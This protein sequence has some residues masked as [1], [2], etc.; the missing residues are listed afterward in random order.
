MWR[1]IAFP[2]KPISFYSTFHHPAHPPLSIS[3]VS[4]SALK[5]GN[6]I[7][8]INTYTVSGR[9]LSF[10][11]LNT[12]ATVSHVMCPTSQ[13]GFNYMHITQALQG[14]C[15]KIRRDWKDSNLRSQLNEG[16]WSPEKHQAD[17]CVCVTCHKHWQNL[18]HVGL[19]VYHR[20]DAF[21][22]YPRS[23]RG[24]LA[25]MRLC[26]MPYYC[27]IKPL[28]QLIR[29]L[30]DRHIVLSNYNT[31]ITI[32][33]KILLKLNSPGLCAHV[34]GGLHKTQSNVYTR[35]FGNSHQYITFI[36]K[37]SSSCK[38]YFFSSQCILIVTIHFLINEDHFQVCS[39]W[40]ESTLY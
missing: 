26:A 14:R 29:F 32:S 2:T 12:L 7:L 5:Q 9:L 19:I 25:F 31:I 27:L 10:V 22:V 20:F 15:P 40:H 30:P 28:F 8:L 36:Q 6:Q 35:N 37:I 16:T 23:A 38:A 3:C 34:Y 4:A 11:S 1:Q 13:N 24:P 39:V 33:T 17:M 21:W 18:R